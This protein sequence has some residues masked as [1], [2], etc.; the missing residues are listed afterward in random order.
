MGKTHEQRQSNRSHTTDVA[1]T[2]AGTGG[3]E[4]GTVVVT[5]TPEQRERN[6]AAL[7]MLRRWQQEDAAR[8][9]EEVRELD[10]QWERFKKSINEPRRG[11]RE[12]IVD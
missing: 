3:G 7:E 5:G 6:E 10:E 4:A 12:V 9:P 1:R 8:T 11:Y 2:A